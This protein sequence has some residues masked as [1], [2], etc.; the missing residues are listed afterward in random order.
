MGGGG[1]IYIFFPISIPSKEN[2]SLQSPPLLLMEGV[3]VFKQTCEETSLPSFAP[4][5]EDEPS[6][7]YAR[8]NKE[9]APPRRMAWGE[10]ERPDEKEEEE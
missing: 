3:K 10:Q 2:P 6:V 4:K 9:R 5:V 1:D 8:T 7:S